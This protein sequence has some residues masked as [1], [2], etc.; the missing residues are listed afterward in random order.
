[1]VIRYNQQ[2]GGCLYEATYSFYFGDFG[3]I[4]VQVKPEKH[5]TTRKKLK[6]KKRKDNG[7]LVYRNRIERKK[8]EKIMTFW[9]IEIESKEKKRKDNGILVYRNR[10]ER[11]EKEK[12]M[13]FWCIE[14]ESYRK[15]PLLK[16]PL[17]RSLSFISDMLTEYGFFGLLVWFLDE[18]YDDRGRMRNTK[19]PRLL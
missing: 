14:I 17:F 8:K 18:Y 12:I 9:C 3:H 6:E 13:A 16:S 11:K 10:I 5:K 2:K 1:M 15:T 4:S 7:I 19:I